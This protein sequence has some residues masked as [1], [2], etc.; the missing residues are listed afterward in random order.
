MGDLHSTFT[1]AIPAPSIDPKVPI[2]QPG[3]ESMNSPFK[4]GNMGT[5]SMQSPAIPSGLAIGNLTQGPLA[6]PFRDGP[7]KG[8]NS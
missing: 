7:M 3:G 1:D 5:G 4:D 6:T 8:K 2:S